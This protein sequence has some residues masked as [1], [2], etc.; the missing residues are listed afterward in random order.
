MLEPQELGRRTR[1]L[2]NLVEPVAAAVFFVPEAHDA[3]VRLG[4]PPP[5]GAEDG[6]PLFDWGAYFVS[7]AACLGQ[8]HGAVVAAAFGV[9]EPA[10]V[11]REIAQGWTRTD[12]AT[13][14][15]AR[16]Q[17]AVTALARLLGGV[18]PGVERATA[19]LRRG[20]AAVSAAGKPVFAGL[21][22]LGW[23]GTPMGDLWRACDLYREHRGDAH[24]TSWTSYGLNGCEACIINDL[25]QGLR[26]GSYV[27]TRGWSRQAVETA[28]AA[29]RQRGWLDGDQLSPAGRAAREA[30]ETITDNQQRPILAAIDEDFEELVALLTPWRHAIIAGHGYPGRAFVERQG[31]RA[32]QADQQAKPGQTGWA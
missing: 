18:P 26:L 1:R 2:R 13:M 14:L 10:W 15:A 23:P 3:Y 4:F 24:V 12:P 17:S 11:E 9:F 28:I 27:R 16:Q 20:L 30:M 19:V 7:R 29:L 21:W 32:T 5:R 31:E 8:V 22:A 6:I 25:H